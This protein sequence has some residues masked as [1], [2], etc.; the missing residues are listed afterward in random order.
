MQ[1][2]MVLILCG[3]QKRVVSLGSDF[4]Q[5]EKQIIKVRF[6]RKGEVDHVREF[7]KRHYESSLRNEITAQLKTNDR[8]FKDYS[9]PDK[10]IK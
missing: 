3:G 2:G 9:D 5:V 8:L 1:S 10:E 6:D 7:K 4:E